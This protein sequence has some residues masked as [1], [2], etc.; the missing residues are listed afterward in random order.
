MKISVVIPTYNRADSLAVVLPSL[1][2]Q[3]FPAESYELLLCDAGSTDG[4]EELVKELND[5][6]LV[7]DI[8]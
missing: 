1:L 7:L 5:S 8:F 6:R 2:D 4:T 3:T